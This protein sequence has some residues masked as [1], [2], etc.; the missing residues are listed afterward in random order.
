MSGGVAEVTGAIPSPRADRAIPLKP[1]GARR[2]ITG[3]NP[4]AKLEFIQHSCKKIVGKNKSIGA[5]QFKVFWKCYRLFRSICL[6][7]SIVFLLINRVLLMQRNEIEVLRLKLK[8][9]LKQ[10]DNQSSYDGMSGLLLGLKCVFKF[11]LY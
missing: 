9:L 8:K 4:G 7:I 11:R 10:L 6:L 3:Q 2:G 1:S 5:E